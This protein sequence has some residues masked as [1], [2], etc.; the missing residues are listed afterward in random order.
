[1]VNRETLYLDYAGS[2]PK[3][4]DEGEKHSDTTCQSLPQGK[5]DAAKNR[6]QIYQKSYIIYIL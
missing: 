3:G 6:S 2:I 1:M 5:K 4:T